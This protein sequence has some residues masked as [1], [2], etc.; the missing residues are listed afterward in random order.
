VRINSIPATLS[1]IA[2]ASLL[3]RL[4]ATT[5]YS[6]IPIFMHDNVIAGAF[7]IVCWA[8]AA[9]DPLSLHAFRM[10]FVAYRKATQSAESPKR[11]TWL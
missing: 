9:P 2:V 11:M 1:Q 10:R 7:S 3:T 6:R 8:E 5:L 4:D